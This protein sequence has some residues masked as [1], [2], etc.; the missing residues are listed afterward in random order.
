MLRKICCL[1]SE[2]CDC[3]CWSL[4]R[5]KNVKIGYIVLILFAYGVLLM[6]NALMYPMGEDV[7][8]AYGCETEVDRYEGFNKEKSVCVTRTGRSYLRLWVLCIL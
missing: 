6:V 4:T 3:T 5:N 8:V 7:C 2:A 1:N